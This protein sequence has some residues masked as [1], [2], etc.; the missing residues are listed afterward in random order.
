MDII[1]PILEK[2][3]IFL[4]PKQKPRT[5]WE[6]SFKKMHQNRDDKLIIP[7]IFEDEKFIELK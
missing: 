1:E 2:D 4:K 5:G 3:H 7:D 6:K